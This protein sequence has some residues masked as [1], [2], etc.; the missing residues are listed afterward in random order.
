[1]VYRIEDQQQPSSPT[2]VQVSSSRPLPSHV[3]DPLALRVQAARVSETFNAL[4]V[5]VHSQRVALG[6]LQHELGRLRQEGV[7][8]TASGGFF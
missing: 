6:E 5:E 8:R 4:R 1:M 3:F 2:M 7:R